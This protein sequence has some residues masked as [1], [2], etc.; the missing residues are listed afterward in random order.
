MTT[1][2]YVVIMAG[3]AGTR[4]WPLS[5]SKKPKQFLNILNK[6]TTLL[7]DTYNR[8][9]KLCSKENI[10]VITNKDYEELV[11]K[12]LPDLPTENIWLEPYRKNTAPCVAYA[13]YK[14]REKNP[15]AVMLVL[16]SD[17]LIKNEEEFVTAVRSCFNKAN[18]ENCLITI[19]IKP[20]RPNTGYGYI[21]FVQDAVDSKDKYIFKV[22]TFIE[23][24]NLEMAKYFVKSGEFLWNTG[25]FIWSIRSIID[26]FENFDKELAQIFSAGKGIYYT[27]K[28]KLFIE[29]AYSICKNISIDYAILEKANNVYV[30]ATALA[31]SDVGTWKSLY[32]HL[33]KDEHKNAIHG[34]NV[35]VYDS[36]K[37][38]VNVPNN[39]LV[40]LVGLKDLIIVESNNTLLICHKDNE[41]EIRNVVNEIRVQKGDEFV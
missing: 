17:H 11:K 5:T 4:F 7:Q 33:Q 39:K 28:E 13:A 3:G 29:H 37:C 15:N 22:K 31:W 32:E 14:L 38:L 6:G 25:I 16:S 18:E 12:Q 30:R 26:A 24:P 41:Q 10:I 27:E 9:L 19:G 21:Q 8:S 40:V 2:C 23:K 36:T 1:S 20:K 34:K 35:M